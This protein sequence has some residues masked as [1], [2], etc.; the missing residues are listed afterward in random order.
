MKK[1]SVKLFFAISFV[2]A[3]TFSACKPNIV[4]PDFSMGEIDAS[5]YIAFGNDYTAG[6]LN[7]VVS[8]EGQKKGFAALLAKQFGIID[9]TIAF[10]L[11]LMPLGM[12]DKQLILDKLDS[13]YIGCPNKILL[14]GLHALKPSVAIDALY[15][16]FHNMGS[17]NMK[18]KDMPNN[19]IQKDLLRFIHQ[20]TTYI[21]AA[22]SM[23]PTFF[24]IEMGFADVRNYAR[25]GGTCDVGCMPSTRDFEALY[26]RMLDSLKT[27]DNN[28]VIF[29]IPDIT[30]MPYLTFGKN[31]FGQNNDCASSFFYIED[32]NG[33]I[34]VA[35][36]DEVF[37][38]TELENI[39]KAGQGVHSNNPIRDFYCLDATEMKQLKI[40]ISTYNTIIQQLATTYDLAL[41]DMNQIFHE[42]NTSGYL[43]DGISLNNTYITG[44]FYS[45]DGYS[46]SARGN[47]YITNRIIETLNTKYRANIPF[48]NLGDYPVVK[49]E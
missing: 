27:P 25:L 29:T 32:H 30:E 43:Q 22:K 38:L 2:L 1:T 39:I 17:P 40:Y 4:N 24:S 36:K 16:E 10:N 15:G 20:N 13:I 41:V 23:K 34:S 35:K 11:P 33:N 47:A 46:L 26:K 45:I 37:L 8:E 21:D 7:N 18:I 5:N 48:L 44:G 19:L 42:I 28:G 3:I 31:Y 6:V 9:S 12:M 14:Q 49:V